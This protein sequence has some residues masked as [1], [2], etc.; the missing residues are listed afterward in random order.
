MEHL[1]KQ[2]ATRREEILE[3]LEELELRHLETQ[4]AWNKTVHQYRRTRRKLLDELALLQQTN[5]DDAFAVTA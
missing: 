4:H 2:A 3:T 5:W 1:D